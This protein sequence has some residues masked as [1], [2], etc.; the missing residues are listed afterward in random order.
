MIETGEDQSAYSVG[1]DIAGVADD[2]QSKKI[3]SAGQGRPVSTYAKY[4]EPA[5]GCEY[6]QWRGLHKHTVSK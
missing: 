1:P 3:I 6:H 5:N 2:H 4:T